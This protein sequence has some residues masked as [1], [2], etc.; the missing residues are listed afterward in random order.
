MEN[1]NEKAF[2]GISLSGGSAM[3][4][5]FFLN[6]D[7]RKVCGFS[8][9]Q[10]QVDGEIAR[11][12]QALFSSRKDLYQ[13]KHNLSSSEEVITIIDTH[14]SMLED[15]LMTE[16]MEDQIRSSLQTPESVFQSVIGAYQTRFS[17]QTNPFF[18]Q[19]LNDVADLAHRVL[20]HLCS[21]VESEWDQIPSGVI[22]LA[23]EL[24]PLQIA[25]LAALSVAGV[26]TTRG[27]RQSHAALIAKAK[28]LPYVAGIDIEICHKE[29][30]EW[31]IIDG[32]RGQL[33]LN[34]HDQ[35]I[36]RYQKQEKPKAL[37]PFAQTADGHTIHCALNISDPSEYTEECGSADIGLFRTE[38]LIL[39]DAQLAFL[40]EKQKA[41]Y[42]QVL[43]KNK[44]SSCT[45]RLFDIGDDKIPADWEGKEELSS[46][47]G[48]RGI[49]FLL[50]HPQILQIQLQ[51][52]LRA[53][54]HQPVRLLLPFISDVSEICAIKEILQ[55]LPGPLAPFQLGAMIELPSAALCIDAIL[56]EVDFI[57]LGTND[58][59]QY[60][61]GIDRKLATTHSFPPGA[62]PSILQLLHRVISKA[63]EHGKQVSICGDMGSDP[64]FTPLL[65][66]L[67]LRHFSCSCDSFSS[68]QAAIA[69]TTLQESKTKA[70]QALRC[71]RAE[72][73]F[74]L[75]TSTLE[76]SPIYQK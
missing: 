14:L 45:I 47:F 4:P 43:C 49:R 40:E 39:Q 53:S 13:L 75:L 10:S 16:Q 31:A 48:L 19:R 5:L 46:P 55:T 24:T 30:C 61:L 70:E 57:S 6:L 9:S 12:R 52:L 33:L 38:C 76:N 35:T 71:T 50:H 62:H 8:I 73:V 2:P 68:V 54:S 65:L 29:Y 21:Q 69:R 28:K 66:G 58:L 42:E 37:S 27:G 3:G 72:E 1:L 41:I 22:V 59:I 25:T 23:T 17:K 74:Q 63:Q 15:P 51:A 67:G 7:K 36:H 64:L 18:Q 56:P 11:Y 26:V 34:P 44:E 60:T 32:N 20:G